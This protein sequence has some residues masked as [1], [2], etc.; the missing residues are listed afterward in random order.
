MSSQAEKPAMPAGALSGFHAA[1]SYDAHRP[2]YPP[3]AFLKLLDVTNLTPASTS[4][5]APVKK[6]VVDLAAGTGKM[7]TLLAQHR[8]SLRDTNS[9]LE[10]E[11]IAVEPHGDMREELVKKGIPGLRVLVG[12]AEDIPLEDSSVDVVVV[13]QVSNR[14]HYSKHEILIL[15]LMY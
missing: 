3:S 5:S 9:E 1:S 11:L 2:S 8:D 10:I 4:T 6:V 13:A 7:T 14:R 15:L 12:T